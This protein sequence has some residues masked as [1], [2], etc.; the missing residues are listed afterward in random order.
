M[1]RARQVPHLN[2]LRKLGQHMATTVTVDPHA[3]SH[4]FDP[5]GSRGGPGGRFGG[6]GAT[7]KQVELNPVLAR[8]VQANFSE[9]S[10]KMEV[11]KKSQE[12]SEREMN[13][14]TH[15]LKRRVADRSLELTT[16]QASSARAP[17]PLSALSRAPP[18]RTL[19]L[20]CAPRARVWGGWHAP[21]AQG[22]RDGIQCIQQAAY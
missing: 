11:W 6:G 7:A 15:E 8:K 20:V 16:M 21:S 9:V 10:T 17:P 1:C 3:L 18:P 2:G 14:I 5:R 19:G 13:D 4:A 12:K 22:V